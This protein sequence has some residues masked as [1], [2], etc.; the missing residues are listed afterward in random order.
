[1][2]Q[3]HVY[4][5]QGLNA[6]LQ[7]RLF[8]LLRTI[9]RA[10]RNSYSTQSRIMTRITTART[11]VYNCDFKTANECNQC[12]TQPCVNINLSPNFPL[13]LMCLL[14][15]CQPAYLLG[16]GQTNGILAEVI[17]R[18][19][20]A[21]E[22]VA[23][24]D[25]RTSRGGDIHALEGRDTGALEL[26]DVVSGGETVVGASQVEGDVRKRLDLFALDS[27]LAVPA[28]LSTN[29]LVEQLSQGAGEDVQGGTSVKD[30]TGSL[31][32]S[33]LVPKGNGFDVDFPIGLAAKRDIFNLAGVVA[34]VNTAKNGL[35]AFIAAAEVE[36]KDGLVQKLLVDHLVEGRNDLVDGDG[37][38]AQA[39]NTIETAKGKG[40]AGLVGGLSKVLVLD[41][42]VTD[43]HNVVGDEARQAA[44]AVLD[45]KI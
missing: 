5:S 20:A 4:Y 7:T 32:L 25:K 26:E 29:L 10:L 19:V 41:L 22:S 1:M 9:K 18:V 8:T 30:S 35:A 38:V 33:N 24:D 39:K 3:V 12:E 17:D 31:E 28:L 15:H 45:L 37:V 14:Y 36:G 27:V 42:Q 44:R 21:Q 34:L 23:Q 2:M 6:H 11:S 16:A 40:K 43:G 13:D